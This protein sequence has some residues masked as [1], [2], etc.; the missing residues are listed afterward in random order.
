[1]GRNITSMSKIIN[2][3]RKYKRE[4]C[5]EMMFKEENKRRR[6]ACVT[7]AQSLTHIFLITPDNDVCNTP[8]THSTDQ[9]TITLTISI[10]K[11]ELGMGICW[12]K[13]SS[14]RKR[15]RSE[16]IKNWAAHALCMGSPPK[17]FLLSFNNEM[18]RHLS[19][20][21]VWHSYLTH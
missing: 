18:R 4:A 16:K 13:H 19:S 6:G 12:A 5:T 7:Q 9:Y 20:E 21:W 11:V 10:I 3:K 17:A 1:M 2:K 15:E 8:P 14:E